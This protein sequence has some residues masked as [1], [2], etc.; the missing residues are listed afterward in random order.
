MK[1]ARR[2]RLIASTL[3][4]FVLVPLVSLAWAGKVV[5]VADQCPGVANGAVAG[6]LRD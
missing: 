1:P 6:E 2:F 5:G 4:V 3:L